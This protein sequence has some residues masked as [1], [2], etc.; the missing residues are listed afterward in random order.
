[1]KGYEVKAQQN[2]NTREGDSQQSE[3]SN[4]FRL[5]TNSVTGF[6]EQH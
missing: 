3:K 2:S 4:T 1:M 5:L 6:C